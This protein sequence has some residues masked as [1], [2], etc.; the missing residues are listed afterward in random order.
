MKGVYQA[1]KDT[2]VKPDDPRYYLAGMD[3]TNETLDMIKIPNSSTGRRT[4]SPAP[5]SRTPT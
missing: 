1:L 5:S 2:G 3:V 4:P